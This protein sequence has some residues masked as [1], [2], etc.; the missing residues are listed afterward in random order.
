[1]A[2]PDL[3][4][5][6][7]TLVQWTFESKHLVVF[8]AAGIST[9]SGLPDF[10]GPDGIWTRQAKGLPTEARPFHSVAPNEGHM[11]VAELQDLDKLSFLISENVVG[12]SL[13]VT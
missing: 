11:A 3:D 13:V 2:W 12:S 1:M 4:K 10:R 6:I 9:E 8:T 7:S 5:R